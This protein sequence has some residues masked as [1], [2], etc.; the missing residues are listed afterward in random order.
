MAGSPSALARLQRGRQKGT[1][2]E[3]RES[4]R[5]AKQ[6][7]KWALYVF[8]LGVVQLVSPLSCKVKACL[9]F[10]TVLWMFSL[11]GGDLFMWMLACLACAVMWGCITTGWW[12]LVTENG[13]HWVSNVRK[14]ST[15]HWTELNPVLVKSTIPHLIHTREGRGVHVLHLQVWRCGCPGCGWSDGRS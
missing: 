10:L 7:R 1:I 2:K 11:V 4:P 9:F 13:C 8:P 12:A 3:A 15:L 6:I 5:P 14:L